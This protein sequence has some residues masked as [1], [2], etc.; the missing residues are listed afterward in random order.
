MI[1]C[2][3]FLINSLNTNILTPQ[4]NKKINVIQAEFLYNLFR[5]LIAAIS[6]LNNLCTLLLGSLFAA[7]FLVAI[8]KRP[9]FFYD[10]ENI[11]KGLISAVCFVCLCRLFS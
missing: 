3:L 2:P 10:N 11:K 1:F 6:V 5:I 8:F 9:I 4:T 7:G